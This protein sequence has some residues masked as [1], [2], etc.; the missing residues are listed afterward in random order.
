[1]SRKSIYIWIGIVFVLSVVAVFFNKGNSTLSKKEIILPLAKGEKFDRIT[2]KSGS[3]NF[4]IENIDNRWLIDS[5]SEANIPKIAALVSAL[6]NL[7]MK[8]PASI[9][10]SESLTDTI[11]KNGSV[12][13][14]YYQGKLIYS[15]AYIDFKYH[16]IAL[17]SNKYPVF[18]EIRTNTDIPLG[19]IISKDKTQWN[20]SLL[21]DI[22]HKDIAY[23]KL[24]YPSRPN[25]GFVIVASDETLELRT[26]EGIIIEN[27][28]MENLIDYMKF[29]R[30]INYEPQNSKKYTTNVNSDIFS[31]EIGSKSGKNLMLRGY[32]L[33][34]VKS[35]IKDINIFKGI[36][37]NY[38]TIYLKYSN[39]DP[40]L[41]S[42]Q[43]FLKN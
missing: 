34:Q 5:S 36:V 23:I 33:F 6:E 22:E 4:F 17:N 10:Q 37:N 35:G 15:L 18:I 12:V 31:L 41:T 11:N 26:P 29:F 3:G 7:Q 27:V 42:R 21:I 19:A 1:M 32:D 8:Y 38:D 30:G 2:I 20:K 43:Y 16:T 13:C 25:D 14:L 40:I 28:E 9:E 24:L 39:I